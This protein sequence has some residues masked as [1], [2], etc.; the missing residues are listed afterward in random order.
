VYSFSG[1]F[2]VH[3]INLLCGSNEYL[4]SSSPQI[5]RACALSIN[6][7]LHC[8]NSSYCLTCLNKDWLLQNGVCK[9]SDGFMQSES[10][11][12]AKCLPA[13]KFNTSLSCLLMDEGQTLETC[14]NSPSVKTSTILTFVSVPNMAL[15]IRVSQIYTFIDDFTYYVYHN[16]SYGVKFDLFVKFMWNLTNERFIPHSIAKF[17]YNIQDQYDK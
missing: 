13:I 4:V 16:M 1:S 12:S 14:I 9:C 7:C 11:I 17:Y 2:V 5:C 6:G 3:R 10:G 8:L 15:F